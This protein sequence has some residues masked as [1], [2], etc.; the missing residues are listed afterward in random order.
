MITLRKAVFEDLP[1]I[2]ELRTHD[3]WLLP[4]TSFDD[5][6]FKYVLTYTPKELK[7]LLK[8]QLVLFVFKDDSTHPTCLIEFTHNV[9]GQEKV[10][11]WNVIDNSESFNESILKELLKNEFNVNALCIHSYSPA[12]QAVL[13]R[14]G[15]KQDFFKGYVYDFKRNKKEAQ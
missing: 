15:F 10:V 11:S 4:E 6:D 13:L 14:N 8:H 5:D 2:N 3:D 9:L 7:K 12:I 1:L